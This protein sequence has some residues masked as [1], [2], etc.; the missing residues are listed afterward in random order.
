M[1]LRCLLFASLQ[2]AVGAPELEIELPDASLAS[3]LLDLLEERHPG[4]RRHRR[5]YRVAVDGEFVDLGHPLREGVEVALL[6][7]VSGGSG[8]LVRITEGPVSVDACLEAV[9][10]ADCGAVVLF[11]GTVRNHTHGKPVERLEYSSYERMALPLLQDL[12]AQVRARFE[13]GEVAL[14][15]RTGTLEP[16]EI[17]V[18]CAVSSGHRPQAFEAARWAID[19]LKETIPL[20]KKEIGEGGAVWIEG[21]SRHPA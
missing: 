8:G 2:T 10:R 16:G 3:D 12:A 14:W 21:D 13:V 5:A 18:V 20:W 15:H 6:P 17:S 11:L 4:V 7:P 19:T 9:R 1:K